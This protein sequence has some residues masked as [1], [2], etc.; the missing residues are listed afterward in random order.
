MWGRNVVTAAGAAVEMVVGHEDPA[1]VWSRAE[2]SWDLFFEG[3][4]KRTNG[5]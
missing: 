2:E 5:S 4:K 3:V 1:E